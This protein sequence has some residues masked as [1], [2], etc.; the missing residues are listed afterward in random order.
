MTIDLIGG[1]AV[2][3]GLEAGRLGDLPLFLVTDMASRGQFLPPFMRAGP[4]A[5][6]LGVLGSTGRGRARL[7][8][9]NRK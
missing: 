6:G 8:Q 3:L 2:S 5:Q 4:T 9:K 7:E 1:V